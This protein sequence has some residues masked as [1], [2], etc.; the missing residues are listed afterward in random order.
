MEKIALDGSGFFETISPCV[1][2]NQGVKT[3]KEAVGM[4]RVICQ[5][6]SPSMRRALSTMVEK[7]KEGKFA[8][9]G[10]SAAHLLKNPVKTSYI[11]NQ[12][13][14]RQSLIFCH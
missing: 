14:E 2:Q 4:S 1:F 8:R 11:D 9:K 7:H 12:K 5:P 6:L 13:L 3:L 10:E